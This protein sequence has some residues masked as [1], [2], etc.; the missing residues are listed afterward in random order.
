[1]DSKFT[2]NFDGLF[3]DRR[4]ESRASEFWDHLATNQVSVIRKMS[5]Q[6]SEQKAYYRL[7][8]NPKVSEEKLIQETIGRLSGNFEG[9]HVLYIQDTSEIN[10]SDHKGRIDRGSGLGRSDK[11]DSAFCFKVHPTLAL[12]AHDLTPLG[13]SAIKVFHRSEEKPNRFVRNYKKQPIEEKES[14]KWIES[15]QVS[16]QTLAQAASIT[17]IEDREGDIYEQFARI[18]DSR[19]HL[20]IRSRTNRKLAN[21]EDMYQKTL[22]SSVT[23]QY[24]VNVRDDIR[25][26]QISR[27]AVIEVRYEECMIQKP[28]TF[29]KQSYPPYIKLYC[30]SAEEQG[31]AANRIKWKLLTTHT[32]ASFEDAMQI[33]EWYAARW[34]IEQVFRLLKSDGFNIESTE[35]ENGWTIR[36]L[37]I[38]QLTCVLKI[39]QMHL[40]LMETAQGQPLEEVFGDDEIAVLT[41]LNKQLQGTTEMLKNPYPKS[42]VKWAAWIIARNGGWGGFKSERKPGVITLK[43]GLDKFALMVEAY[44]IFRDV[45]KP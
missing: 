44:K 26:K 39:M 22:S 40:S 33:I 35:I 27:R 2:P 12:D 38:M 5:K 17:F 42:N 18:P 14:Y 43:N 1:M 24:V 15:A 31:S 11:A 25:K 8:S 10:L 13:Y 9:R 34:Y 21:G 45:G 36:K 3:N 4:L 16:K 23:G 41:V 20:I 7:L 6:T 28:H 19:T 30:I 32:I 29:S 37:L